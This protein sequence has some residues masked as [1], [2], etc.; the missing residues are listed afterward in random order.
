MTMVEGYWR[1]LWPLILIALTWELLVAL[2]AAVVLAGLVWW[3]VRRK[4]K[5]TP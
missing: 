3:G 4:R 5:A 2:G 1:A